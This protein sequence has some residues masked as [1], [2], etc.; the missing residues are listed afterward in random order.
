MS[1]SIIVKTQ[2]QTW[3][4]EQQTW[5][6]EQQTWNVECKHETGAKKKNF[7]VF[8]KLLHGTSNNKHET[9]T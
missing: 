3:N 7:G 2:H 8:E 6:V 9:L 4:I 5:N 1:T